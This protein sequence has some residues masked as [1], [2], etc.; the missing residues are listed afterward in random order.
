MCDLTPVAQGSKRV[1]LCRE[2]R[3]VHGKAAAEAWNVGDRLKKTW[4]VGTGREM[5]VCGRV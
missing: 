2:Q 4:S 3:A 1:W 5:V